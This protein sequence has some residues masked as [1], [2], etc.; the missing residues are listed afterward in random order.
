MAC[1]SWLYLFY[2]LYLFLVSFI[3][4][5]IGTWI[6]TRHYLIILVMINIATQAEHHLP[7]IW[8]PPRGYFVSITWSKP[9][10]LTLFILLEILQVFWLMYE[11]E[12]YD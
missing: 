10:F 11:F 12:I 3:Y 6:Y 5:N 4:D 7:L 8:D 9:L 1:Y 2:S